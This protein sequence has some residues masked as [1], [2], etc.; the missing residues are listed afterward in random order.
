MLLDGAA[1]ASQG[2]GSPPSLRVA[3]VERTG[4]RPQRESSC[5]EQRQ[6]VPLFPGLSVTFL[7]LCKDML[8]SLCLYFYFL[9][10]I[11]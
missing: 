10:L 2:R 5:P 3:E 1:R 4:Y 7:P 9:Q 11:R 6:G 8:F